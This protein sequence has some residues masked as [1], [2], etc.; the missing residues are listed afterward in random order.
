M[1]RPFFLLAPTEEDTTTMRPTAAA[2]FA[3]L[4]FV[5]LPAAADP[6]SASPLPAA[7]ADAGRALAPMRPDVLARVEAATRSKAA[8]AAGKPKEVG[9][10][11]VVV[12]NLTPPRPEATPRM[13]RRM[14]VER[15]VRAAELDA[16]ASEHDVAAPTTMLVS[17]HVAPAGDVERLDVLS[18]TSDGLATC[19]TRTLA[20]GTFGPPGGSGARLT[21]RVVVPAAAKAPSAPAR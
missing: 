16:C 5:A 13:L 2:L 1:R 7:S 21:V 10:A 6:P 12:K 8:N 18:E 19:V 9:A 11:P 14:N 4:A 15:F 3:A 20:K 17:V